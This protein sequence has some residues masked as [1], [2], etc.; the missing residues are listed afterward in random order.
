VQFGGD[1]LFHPPF[2]KPKLA[3]GE[4]DDLSEVK[5]ATIGRNVLKVQDMASDMA[6]HSG[7]NHQHLSFP[8]GHAA[9]G[10]MMCVFGFMASG[11]RRY[12]LWFGSVCLGLLFGWI[13][14]IQGDHFLSDVAFSCPL[15]F[16]TASLLYYVVRS[17]CQWD[18]QTRAL[19]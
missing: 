2:A 15:V 17:Y 18:L 12:I 5:D 4:H 16:A 3:M 9:V 10:Y 11:R 14:V 7:Q 8:S 13:R 6:A 1:A 19:L